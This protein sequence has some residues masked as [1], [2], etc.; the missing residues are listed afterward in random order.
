M[1]SVLVLAVLV[2]LRVVLLLVAI[3]YFLLLHRLVAVLAVKAVGS[4]LLLQ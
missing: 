2:V 4:L 1:R 3:Q